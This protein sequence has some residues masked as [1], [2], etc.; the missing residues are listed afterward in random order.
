MYSCLIPAT[1]VFLTQ[2]QA[3]GLR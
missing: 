1:T 2:Q 3:L